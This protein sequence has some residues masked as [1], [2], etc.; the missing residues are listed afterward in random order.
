VRSDR[1]LSDSCSQLDQRMSAVVWVGGERFTVGTEIGVVTDGT[2]VSV[3]SD[4]IL[5]GSSSADWAIAVD[6]LVLLFLATDHAK[7]LVDR[8]KSVARVYLNSNMDA[9]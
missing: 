1:Q 2:L 6:T 8:N 7:L 4:I 5:S 9:G 3:A